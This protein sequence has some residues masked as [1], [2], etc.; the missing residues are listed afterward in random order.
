LRFHQAALR[1]SRTSLQERKPFYLFVDE[2]QNFAT[3]SFTRILS[4]GRKFGL[5][6]TLAEQSTAQQQDRQVINVILANTGTVICFA[7]ASPLDEQ[8]MESQFSPLV[9]RHDLTNL[10]KYR[11][12]I[13]LSATEPQEPFSGETIKVPVKKDPKRMEKLI[14]ASRR[15]FAI[16]YQKP[17]KEAKEKKHKKEFKKGKEKQNSSL[18]HRRSR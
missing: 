10:P 12:Y 2:F 13:N 18:P 16:V 14:E 17:K 3:T 6:L 5:R 7:T 9:S 1:R 15:N 4:G 11:F 8:M